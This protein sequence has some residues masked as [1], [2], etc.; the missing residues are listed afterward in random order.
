MEGVHLYLPGS[1]SLRGGGREPKA[2]F[3]LGGGVVRL[4][5]VVLKRQLGGKM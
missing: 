5:P 1:V 4:M 3:P 2:I